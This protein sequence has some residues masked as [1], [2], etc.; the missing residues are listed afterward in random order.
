MPNKSRRVHFLKFI[1][2]FNFYFV[3][4]TECMAFVRVSFSSE[5]KEVIKKEADS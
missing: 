2:I 3:Y 4:I 5:Q 1:F